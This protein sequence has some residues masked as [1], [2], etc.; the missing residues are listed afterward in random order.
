MNFGIASVAIAAAAAGGA[1]GEA[2]VKLRAGA[3]M[4]SAFGR[5]CWKANTRRQQRWANQVVM[6]AEVADQCMANGELKRASGRLA[7]AIHR[8][9]QRGA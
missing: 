2:A 7:H 6:M 1:T 4:G 9:R 5:G 3:F 8:V